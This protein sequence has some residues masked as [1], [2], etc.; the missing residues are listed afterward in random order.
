MNDDGP[1][2]SAGKTDIG[3]RR[4]SNQDCYLVARL[5]RGMC[6]DDTSLPMADRLHGR[7]QG[8]VLIVA[9]GMGGHAGGERA[10]ALAI[11][12]LIDRLLDSFHCATDDEASRNDFLSSLETMVQDTHARILVESHNDPDVRGMGTTLTMAYIQ[13]PRMYVAHAGDSRCYVVGKSVR[14]ITE[15]HTMARRL[16][17][18]GGLDP[19]EESTSRWSNVLWNVLGGRNEDN[20]VVQTE[21]VHL[22]PDDVVILCSDGLHRYLDEPTILNFLGEPPRDG[23][24]A[25]HVC[26]RLIEHAREQGGED[27]ITAAVFLS[28]NRPIGYGDWIT[29]FNQQLTESL[30]INPPSTLDPEEEGQEQLWEGDDLPEL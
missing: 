5:R 26:D 28:P 6:V 10:S 20:I 22:E 16:V 19:A 8:E 1:S 27:N 14:Q 24:F 2:Q 17:Q 21:L 3:L 13:W 11:G 4:S 7:M 25:H 29:E 18:S 12:Y 9:D 23:E 30:L 15:D